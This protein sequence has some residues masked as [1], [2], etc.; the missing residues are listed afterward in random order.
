MIAPRHMLVFW[1]EKDTMYTDEP[2]KT[3]AQHALK[4]SAALLSGL[5]LND[6]LTSVTTPGLHHEFDTKVIVK[7]VL[8][9]P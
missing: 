2:N 7:W 3:C 5:G 8:G 1:G 4:R 6:R 9:P